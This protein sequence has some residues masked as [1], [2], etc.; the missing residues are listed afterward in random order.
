M[1]DIKE[2]LKK[3]PDNPGIYLMKDKKDEVIYIGKAKNLKK[4]VKQY[5]QSRNH[6]G[7]I[8]QMIS[9]IDSFEYI[10]TDSELE[11]LMLEANF[12][13]KYRPKYNTMLMD[14][15][16]Y[17][18]IKVTVSEKFPRVMKVRQIKKDGSK[19]FGPYTSA[20][21]VKQTIESIRNIFKIRNCSLKIVTGKE[22]SRPCLNYYIDRCKGPCI[23]KVDSDEYRKGI[24]EV[25][26]LLNGREDRL[27]DILEERMLEA[28]ENLQFEH[29]AE[30]RDRIAAIRNLT[31]KQKITNT[32]LKDMD[33]I[34]LAIGES[35]AIVQ[36]FFIRG[37]KVVGKED[38]LMTRN[39]EDDA[40]DLVS[41]FVKQY[42]SGTVYIPKEIYIETEITDQDLVSQWLG[43]KRGNK[44]ELKIPVKGEKSMLMKMVKKNAEE[45]LQKDIEKIKVRRKENHDALEE[46]S[47]LIGLEHIPLR[48]EGYDISNI[49]GVE[50]VGSM[51][52]LEEGE[53]KKSSYRRFRIKEVMGQDDYGSMEEM[54]ERRINRGLRESSLTEEK[55]GFGKLPDLILVDGGKGHVNIAEEVLK[56][57]GLRIPVAGMVKDDKHATR[58]LIYENKEIMLL[59]NTK[60]YRLISSM[61]NEV[62][63][64]AISYHRNLRKK[65]T[66]KTVLDNIE[67]IGEK[68]KLELIKHFGSVEG[69]KK[70]SLDE[71]ENAPRM[72]SKAAKNVFEFFN[73]EGNVK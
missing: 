23:G 43:E 69:V 34:G 17:P 18:Y 61:Q 21:A 47:E 70:A 49:Q 7:K 50:N 12:I 63:R 71:L 41:S 9:N 46:L 45:K 13:K 53:F 30:Y 26:Q 22:N 36:I 58:G 42:Y 37:G 33:V 14:D 68:R 51:V 29:A 11:A 10:I 31:D 2:E 5:F 60:L 1:F 35:D 65:N 15:K 59:R 3:I 19:Y 27:I 32:N 56:D 64:F 62:H 55:K 44:V 57:H 48:V 25:L 66:F 6:A 20:Y 39:L 4:R 54:L 16:Q 67:G 38:Y 72:N 73:K 52:V 8:Q 24:D 28:S 40:S